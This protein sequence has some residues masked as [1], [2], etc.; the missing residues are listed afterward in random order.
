VLTGRR[1]VTAVLLLLPVFVA[2]VMFTDIPLLPKRPVCHMLNSY[3]VNKIRT[4]RL[5]N[6]VSIP[7]MC[8]ILLSSPVF[9][10]HLVFC[11]L[12]TKGSVPKLKQSGV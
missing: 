12:G 5:R 11:P 9:W 6:Q 8:K 3:T 2:V 4:G 7:E 1:I 10:T